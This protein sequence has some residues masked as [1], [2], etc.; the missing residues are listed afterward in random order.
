LPLL[1]LGDLFYALA[2]SG[3][4]VG[5]IA[6]NLNRMLFERMPRG[7]FVSATI[8]RINPNHRSIEIWNGGM[9]PVVLFTAESANATQVGGEHPALG[10]VPPDDFNANTREWQWDAQYPQRL[11]SYSDGL[12]DAQN[13]DGEIF[14]QGRVLELFKNQVKNRD[15]SADIYKAFIDF[16]DADKAR[17]D[18]SLLIV[19]CELLRS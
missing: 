4:M 5:A 2:R 8:L 14:G 1:P 17:D 15:K 12:T 16:V 11:F 9:P 18:V 6:A 19:D 10:V 13:A 7:R 3:H